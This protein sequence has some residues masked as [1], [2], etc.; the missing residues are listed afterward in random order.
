MRLNPKMK[1]RIMIIKNLE[2]SYPEIMI[3]GKRLKEKNKA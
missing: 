3:R 2:E 1:M